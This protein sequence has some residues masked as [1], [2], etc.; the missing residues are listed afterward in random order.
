MKKTIRFSAWIK[1]YEKV[2]DGFGIGDFAREVSKDGGFPNTCDYREM[3]DYL[4]SIFGVD[5]CRQSFER[6]Y[7]R[8]LNDRVLKV[9]PEKKTK[10][11]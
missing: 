5:L 3:K 6:A 2:E 7:K 4:Y 9:V 10:R 11:R 1:K 8:Y